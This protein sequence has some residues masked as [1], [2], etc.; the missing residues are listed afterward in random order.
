MSAST[1]AAMDC[2]FDLL[3]QQAARRSRHVPTL[4]VL[5]G[6]LL[7]G[8]RRWRAWLSGSPRPS[9]VTALN[10]PAA[11]ARLLTA[12]LAQHRDLGEDALAAVAG[13][14][15]R[16][17]AELRARLDG[18]TAADLDLFLDLLPVDRTRD[19]VAVAILLLRWRQEGSLPAPE[20]LLGR[21]G[22]ALRRPRQAELD[23]L[24]AVAALVP[25]AEWPALFLATEGDDRQPTWLVR[26]SRVAAALATL[27][28]A[29]PVGLAAPRELLEEHLRTAAE[30][31]AVALLREGLIP[32]PAGDRQDL[33]RRVE[34][35]GGNAAA[36]APAIE[37]V[38][39][40]GGDAGLVARLAEAARAVACLGAADEMS[41]D[42]ARSEAERFLFELLDS[43]PASAGLFELN[44][45]LNFRFGPRPAEVDL[46]ARTFRIAVELDGGFW[47]LRDADSY[48]RDRRKDWELQRRGFLV[49]R[50]LAEDVVYRPQEILDT[51]LAAVAYRRRPTD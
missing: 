49:L 33:S 1:A 21:L 27:L 34:E 45:T 13:W 6:P 4:S 23:L 38:L 9:V 22:E 50:F 51:I 39:A 20:Q 46:V 32:L 26:A 43:H 42:R 15:D 29:L 16:P 7:S 2:A 12:S 41:E 36:A 19:P 24:A 11:V 14:C 35:A 8:L 3:D 48:R 25:E 10:G 5:A 28:P 47:H 44:G 40:R 31:K 37:A 18:Q 30:S 17:A